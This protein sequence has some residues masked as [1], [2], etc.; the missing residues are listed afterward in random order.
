MTIEQIHEAFASHGSDK[1]TSH[2]YQH[3]YSLILPRVPSGSIM[4]IGYHRGGGMA[5]LSRLLPY[6]HAVAVDLG[7]KDDNYPDMNVDRICCDMSD[8]SA[9]VGL[10]ARFK[11]GSFGLIIDDASHRFEDQLNGVEILWPLLTPGGL[12]VIED[13]AGTTHAY[14]FSHFP[15]FMA[16][17]TRPIGQPDDL[18]V[19]LA[20]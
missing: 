6:R 1:T 4:E 17:D 12:Y 11:P 2:R 14:R 8:R 16:I 15:G 5:G 13:V 20:A 9:V 10:A 19:V 3:A 7:F 18:C